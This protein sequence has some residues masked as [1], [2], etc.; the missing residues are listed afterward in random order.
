[1]LDKPIM[2]AVYHLSL[3]M[4]MRQ[5]VYPIDLAVQMTRKMRAVQKDHLLIRLLCPGTFV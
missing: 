5:R 2:V 1:M 4:E 3:V